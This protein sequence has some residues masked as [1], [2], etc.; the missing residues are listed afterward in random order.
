MIR[1]DRF[2]PKTDDD[3]D[4]YTR[5]TVDV[6]GRLLIVTDERDHILY[7]GPDTPTWAT[8]LLAWL[9]SQCEI[10]S[11]TDAGLREAPAVR[12]RR[13][14]SQTAAERA[15]GRARRRAAAHAARTR[16]TSTKD[17]SDV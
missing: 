10:G 11:V 1:D 16:T 12:A 7:F 17:G 6:Y 8:P 5:L 4:R 13:P 15:E 2:S 3:S 9:R 14:Q